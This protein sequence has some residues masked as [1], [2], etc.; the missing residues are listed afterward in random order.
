V[1]KLTRKES[2]MKVVLHAENKNIPENKAALYLAD[3]G[4]IGGVPALFD[5]EIATEIRDAWWFLYLMGPEARARWLAKQ[6]DLTR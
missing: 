5:I 4:W 1:G 3:Y 6:D 2:T